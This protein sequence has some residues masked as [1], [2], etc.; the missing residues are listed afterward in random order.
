MSVVVGVLTIDLKAN[1]ASFSQSMEKMSHLSAKTA[2]DIKRSLE[3]IAVA[4]AAMVAGFA[5]GTAALI[6]S[7]VATIGSLSRMAKQ[8]GT[9]ADKFSVLAYAAKL[10]HTELGDLTGSMDRLA[11]AS[12]QAQNGN[13]QLAGVFNRLGVSIADTKGHLRDTSDIFAD[14]AVKFSQMG[15]GAGKAALAMAVFG[16]GGA[17]MIPLLNDYGAHQKE[18]TEEAEKFGLVIGG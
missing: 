18:I 17:Q 14:V 1:T 3:K 16:R 7:S 11:K 10:N 15:T 9:T 4:G 5:T 6:E 8:A 13:H 2:N 12:F